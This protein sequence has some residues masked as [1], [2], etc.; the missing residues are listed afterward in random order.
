[1]HRAGVALVVPPAALGYLHAVKC[2]T[3]ASDNAVAVGTEAAL[4]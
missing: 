2:G 3:T 1:M 4:F